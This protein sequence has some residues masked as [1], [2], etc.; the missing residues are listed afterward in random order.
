[1]FRILPLVLAMQVTG[2]TNPPPEA[3]A[4]D[5]SL[6]HANGRISPTVIAI[7][8]AAPI[9]LDGVLDEEIW[10]RAEP[11]T[12]FR[13]ERPG[14]GGPAAERTEVRVVYDDNAIYVGARLYHEDTKTLSRRLGRRDAFRIQTDKFFALIDPHHDHRTAVMMGVTSVGSLEDGSISNDRLYPFDISWNPVWEARTTIDSAGWWAEMRIP[15]SQLRFSGEDTQV[16]GIQFMRI[17]Q[18]AGE[19]SAWAWTPPTEPGYVSK[20]GHLLGI[21]QI[22]APRRL[23]VVPYVLPQGM[24]TEGADP[25]SPFNDGSLYQFSGGADIKYGV[26]SDLTLDLSVNPDFGQVDADPAVVNLTNFVSFFPELRPLFVEGANIFDFGLDAHLN[27]GREFAFNLEG[28][29]LF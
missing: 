1:M 23:E 20:F 2:E 15:F 18:R 3:G 4:I 13:R 8:S 14:D 21:S 9:K 19:M 12:G 25:Q 7:R 24:F 16:W 27:T 17:I 28:A 26:T 11:V 6:V 5:S 10:Q 22:R 29:S